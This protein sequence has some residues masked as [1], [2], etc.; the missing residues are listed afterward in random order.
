MPP[1]NLAN[2]V[3]VGRIGIVPLV[4]HAMRKAQGRGGSPALAAALFNAVALSD[5]IDGHLA[6]R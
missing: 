2:A 6:L 5:A 4:V 1:V 3:T